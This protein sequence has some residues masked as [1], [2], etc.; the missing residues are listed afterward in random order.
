MVSL[1]IGTAWVDGMAVVDAAAD[2]I[3]FDELNAHLEVS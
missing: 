2:A 3:L 1:P